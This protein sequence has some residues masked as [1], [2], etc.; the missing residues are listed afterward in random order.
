MIFAA[1]ILSAALSIPL[2]SAFVPST[3]VPSTSTS[4]ALC[5]TASAVNNVVLSPSDEADKFDSYA[6]G[7]PRVHR[8]LRDDGSDDAE[9]GEFCRMVFVS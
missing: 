7:T 5:S 2:A 4:S 8:Y 3:H 6:I 1:H 9:Y